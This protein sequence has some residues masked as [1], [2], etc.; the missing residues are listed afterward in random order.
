[1][2]KRI[3][4][5]VIRSFDYGEGN[6]IIRLLTEQGKVTLMAK[7][8]KKVK[9]R[10]GA[11]SQLFTQ[12]DFVFYQSGEMGTLNAGETIHSFHAIRSDL[13]KSAYASYLTELVDRMMEDNEASQAIYQQLLAALTAIESDKDPEL[14]IHAFELKMLHLAG[15]T[16]VFSHCVHCGQQEKGL[17]A[18]S[19]S[20]GGMLC[21]DCLQQDA[22]RLAMNEKT[23]KILALLQRLD[24][25]RLGETKVSA[26]TRK[27]MKASMNA[28]IDTHI[29]LKLKSRSF[30]EQMEKYGFHES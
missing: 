18:F 6:K 26:Q 7:G 24:L 1:M 17:P 9:S 15:Y 2:I 13:L 8:A 16:P 29:Q 14:I 30:L 5:I 10:H 19:P 27:E 4:G 23:L 22:Y 20:L 12:A 25:R 3:E 28:F 21:P 11:V